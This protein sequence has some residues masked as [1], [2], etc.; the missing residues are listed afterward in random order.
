MAFPDSRNHGQYGIPNMTHGI[1]LLDKPVGPT[2]NRVLGQAKRLLGVRKAGHTGALDPRA[3]GLLPICIGEATKICGFL[4]E[5]DKTY[6]AGIVLGVTTASG[7]SEG[8]V[9]D[10]RPVPR[11]A[12]SDVESV[13]EDFR[14]DIEQVPPMY[15][16]LKHKGRRLHELARRGEEVERAPRPVTLHRLEID[17]FESP[18]LDVTVTC[19]KGTYIRSLAMDIGEAL[20]CGAHLASLRR[21]ACEPF[22]LERSLTLDELDAMTPGQRSGCLLSPDDAFPDWPCVLLDDV[23]AARVRQGQRLRVD[24]ADGAVRLYDNRG[25]LGL[26]E[27]D[28]GGRLQPKRLFKLP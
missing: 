17:A 5:A 4:L 12:W 14:G 28:D 16:A 7:D 19:S 20:G 8:D 15:S 25:F 3:G 23:Q 11:L 24:H 22:T 10:E 1:L 13:L 18:R 27:I 21:T 26:G 6:E 9:V 2:S